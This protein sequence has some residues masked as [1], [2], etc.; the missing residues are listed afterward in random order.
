MKKIVLI[1]IIL[2]AASALFAQKTQT[3]KPP[4][5][6]EMEEM[7]KEAQKMMGELSEDDKKMMDSLGIKMPDFKNPPKVSDKQLAKAWEDEN[8]VVPKKDAARIAA[9]SKAVTDARMEM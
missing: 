7:M 3:E 6:K 4:T 2:F 8:R 9:I 1:V 5:Q